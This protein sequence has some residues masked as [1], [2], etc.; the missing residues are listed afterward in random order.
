MVYMVLVNFEVHFLRLSLEIVVG[1]I[2]DN[3]LHL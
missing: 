1:V 3:Y 2:K